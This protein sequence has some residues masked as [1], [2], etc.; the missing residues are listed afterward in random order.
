MRRTYVRSLAPACLYVAAFCS[1]FV[2]GLRARFASSPPARLHPQ[3]PPKIDSRH[4]VAEHRQGI[5]CVRRKTDK[6]AE[7]GIAVS[8]LQSVQW[9]S[10]SRGGSVRPSVRGTEGRK[11]LKGG[12]AAATN[13]KTLLLACRA[14][15]TSS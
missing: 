10:L 9:R 2:R 13:N 8:L 4:G 6:G 15:R 14:A 5:G 11:V 1:V 12:A 3:P 7:E